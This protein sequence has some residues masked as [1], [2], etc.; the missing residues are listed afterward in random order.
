MA[1]PVKGKKGNIVMLLNPAEKRA[2]ALA[3]LQDGI[4]RTNDYHAKKDAKG[5]PQRLTKVERAYRAGYVQAGTDSA[6]CFKAKHPRYK[7]KTF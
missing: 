3:E 6:K 7:R 5:R 4:K 2:K 1:T